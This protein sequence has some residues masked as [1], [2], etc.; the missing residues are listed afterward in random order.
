M[1]LSASDL[2]R[3]EALLGASGMEAQVLAALRGSFAR[4]SL[5]RCG[6]TDLGAELPFRAL[7]RFDL[8]LVDGTVHCWRPTSDPER[9]TGLVVVTYKENA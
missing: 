9:A 1:G 6:P 2:T 8:Y 7:G 5:T 4:L 3:I